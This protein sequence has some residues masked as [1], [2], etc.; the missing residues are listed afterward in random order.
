MADRALYVVGQKRFVATMRKAGADMKELKS[1]NRQAAD[2]AAPAVRSRAPHGK[3]G[4]LAASIRAGATQKAGV[5]RAGRKSVPYAG[6]INYGWPKRHIRPRTFV[7]DAVAA[8]EPEWT[9]LY[10]QFIRKTLNQVQGA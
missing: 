7:N 9:R 10:E 2:L 4:K 6:V 3:S 8:T 5:V 1:V